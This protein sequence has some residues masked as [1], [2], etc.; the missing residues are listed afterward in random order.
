MLDKIT[1]KVFFYCLPENFADKREYPHMVIALGEGLTKLGIELYSNENYWQLEPHKQEY[2]FKYDPQVKPE[3]CSIVIINHEWFC[4]GKRDIPENL[5][6]SNRQYKTVLIDNFES[7]K[8]YR[9]L[10]FDPEFGGKFDFILKAHCGSKFHYPDNIIPWAFG[11]SDRILREVAEVPDFLERKQEL[12]VNYRNSIFTSKKTGKKVDLT[13][14]VRKA[15]REEFE[16]AINSLIPINKTVDNSQDCPSE[17]Y[18]YLKWTQTGK[19]HYPDYY[20]RLQNSAACACFGG[21]FVPFLL[22]NPGGKMS[23]IYKGIYRRI[24]WR[25]T[26]I[27]QWDS[28]RL[29]ESWGAGCATFHLDFEKYGVMLPVM[30][31]NWKHYIGID[32]DNLQKAVDKIKNEPE[33]LEHV[34]IEGR[35]WAIENYSPLATAQHFLKI[36]GQR[37][38]AV[39]QPE[40]LNWSKLSTP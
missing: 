29:W 27:L 19:R 13:H 33:I 30:P 22:Q 11:F 35:K 40:Y 18:D 36:V 1:K 39:K 25:S 16:P 2:L 6:D 10:A 8:G 4:S 3:D 23:D 15:V 26:K 32:L 20:Q 7:N 21:W 12:L 17:P 14:T 24:G 38:P 31:E 28:W 34:A 37:D 9:H 5:F